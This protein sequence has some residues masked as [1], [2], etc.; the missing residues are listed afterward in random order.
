MARKYVYLAIGR[1]DTKLY[2]FDP[3][4]WEISRVESV[5]AYPNG[6]S[7]MGKRD[8][9]LFAVSKDDLVTIDLTNNK[10][11]TTPTGQH[12]TDWGWFCGE[13]TPDEK[14]LVVCSGPDVPVHWFDLS[15]AHPTPGNDAGAGRWD[16]W[17]YHPKDGRLYAVEGD[18]GDLLL[19][20]WSRNPVKVLLKEQ[21][22]LP[23]E[24]SKS[25]GRKSYSAVFFDEDGNM[26]AIDSRGNVSVLDLTASTAAHP[27]TK[28]TIGKAKRI[29]DKPLPV[30]D[31][32]VM[33]SAG[34]VDR[35]PVIEPPVITEPKD[36]ASVSARQTV[37]GT[38][39]SGVEKVLLYAVIDGVRTPLGPAVLKGTV[40]TYQPTQ[41]WSVGSH[42]VLA[43]W[44]TRASA[45]PLRRPCTS[46]SPRW[47][48][49]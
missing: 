22:F 11:T 8:H 3:V 37:R 29:G 47:R 26:Y 18:N 42:T 20:D 5:P 34:R 17:S 16:D 12:F 24:K 10:I 25:G 35:I 27:A 49:P 41:D 28:E 2:Q 15:T 21:V 30:G 23:A 43:T 45:T 6:Y 38:V 1:T 9:E 4:E 19:I 44:R 46:P 32:E 33:N 36:Q 48:P 13:V 40:W 39:A 14:S 7:A 31:L